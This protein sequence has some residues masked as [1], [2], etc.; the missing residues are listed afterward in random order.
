MISPSQI[1][2]WSEEAR[3]MRHVDFKLDPPK[4]EKIS[5]TVC[6][7]ANLEDGNEPRCIIFGLDDKKDTTG[8][9]PT[10]SLSLKDSETMGHFVKICD[11]VRNIKP[12]VDIKLHTIEVT[13]DWQAVVIEVFPPADSFLRFWKGIPYTRNEKPETAKMQPEQVWW[14][15]EKKLRESIRERYLSELESN[16]KQCLAELAFLMENDRN[17]T[18]SKNS[19][20]FVVDKYKIADTDFLWLAINKHHLLHHDPSSTFGFVTPFAR[21]VYAAL[22]LNQLNEEEL[23]DILSDS[24]WRHTVLALASISARRQLEFMISYFLGQGEPLM[25]WRCF[26]SRGAEVN[27]ETQRK[28]DLIRSIESCL[29]VKKEQS[30]D[31]M[32]ALDLIREELLSD[33][34]DY[35]RTELLRLLEGHDLPSQVALVLAKHVDPEIEPSYLVRLSF[36][37]TLAEGKVAVSSR[38]QLVESLVPFAKRDNPN[39]PSFEAVLIALARFCRGVES[40]L[41]NPVRESIGQLLARLEDA[42]SKDTDGQRRPN[43]NAQRQLNYLRRI[44]SDIH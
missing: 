32:V 34:D 23:V 33:R 9:R 7:L 5:E 37:R 41:S 25:A 3:E 15:H 40:K 28:A 1:L 29:T 43:R 2:K 35:I 19:V 22:Y 31:R 11:S 18:M 21:R 17:Q 42:Y 6:A 16:L 10:K 36:G 12:S 13:P 38:L 4:P 14:F 44:V 26:L 20:K 30:F 27:I 8:H 24:R 39:S